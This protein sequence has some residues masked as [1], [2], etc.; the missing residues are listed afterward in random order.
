MLNIQGRKPKICL[1]AGH[2]NYG[3]DT[4]A[5]GNGLREQDI[6]LD[7]VLRIKPL[8]ENNG[9]DVVL[10][11]SGDYVDGPHDT[12]VQSLQTRCDIANNAG[13]DFFDSIHV[14]AGGGTGPEICIQSTGGQAEDAANTI[15]PYLVNAG[16]WYNRGV[17]V[18]NLQVTRDTNM[19]AILVENGFI[20]TT[21]DAQKLADPNFRQALAEA[22]V[23]GICKFF[24]VA[25]NDSQYEI[26]SA[27]LIYTQDDLETAKRLFSKYGLCPIFFRDTINKNVFSQDVYKAKTLIIVGGPSVNHPN[28][29]LLSGSNWFTTN[30]ATGKYLGLL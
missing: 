6:T 26:D 24:N 3:A 5:E 20:D 2:N 28:E 27:I 30:M 9:F 23:M 21:T 17:K 19:P 10:T 18:R 29:I 25:Y 22:H 11:R 14:N 12:L 15:L 7:L 8:L 13:V 4:G 16:D 1:D